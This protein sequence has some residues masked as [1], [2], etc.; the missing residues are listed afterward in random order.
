MEQV[1]T[2]VLSIKMRMNKYEWIR[3]RIYLWQYWISI[4]GH[5]SEKK[6]YNFHYLNPYP[7]CRIGYF[8]YP[9]PKGY[10]HGFDLN[11]PNPFTILGVMCMTNCTSFCL[12]D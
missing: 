12:L 8:V 9:H 11:N 4:S 5:I 6:K 1:N 3:G 10:K 7:Y 2:C